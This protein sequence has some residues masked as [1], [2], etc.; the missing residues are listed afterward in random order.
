MQSCRHCPVCAGTIALLFVLCGAAVRYSDLRVSVR[1]SEL[2][3]HTPIRIP[4]RDPTP[5]PGPDPNPNGDA[6][7][8]SEPKGEAPGPGSQAVGS[9]TPPT[10][11]AAPPPPPPP[12]PPP[13]LPAPQGSEAEDDERHGRRHHGHVKSHGHG[14]AR[15]GASDAAPAA[16]E[17]DSRFKG[18]RQADGGLWYILQSMVGH[19]VAPSDPNWM[20]EGHR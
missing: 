2:P 13:P 3:K 6:G 14:L 5:N 7:A 11:D 17:E 16:A 12:A 10:T 1:F 15:T 20:K 9:A 4:D 19:P 8:I 18:Y